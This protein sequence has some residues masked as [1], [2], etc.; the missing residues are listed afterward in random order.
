MAHEAE[1]AAIDRLIDDGETS[2]EERR[3][4]KTETRGESSVH[5]KGIEAGTVD[6]DVLEGT[7]FGSRLRVQDLT[8]TRFLQL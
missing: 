5:M 3:K 7:S 4:R 6:R 1:K 2:H 8:R